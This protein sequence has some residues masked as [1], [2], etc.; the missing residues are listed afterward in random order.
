M[1][2]DHTRVDFVTFSSI[3]LKKS[4]GETEGEDAGNGTLGGSRGVFGRGRIAVGTVPD[5]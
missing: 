3:L 4:S 5:T 1:I 2:S